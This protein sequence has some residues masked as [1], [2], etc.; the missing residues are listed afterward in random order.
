[1]TLQE[2]IETIKIAQAEVEWE[3]TMD[4]AAA[5]DMAIEALEKQIPA[6]PLNN[7]CPMCRRH[8]RCPKQYVGYP[9]KVKNRRGDDYCPKCGQAI[10]WSEGDE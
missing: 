1:M 9:A 7:Y 2:A 4:Y 8:L 3:Y 5:F 6:K 10:D